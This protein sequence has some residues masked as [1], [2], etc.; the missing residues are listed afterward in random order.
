MYD[1]IRAE[2]L[3]RK[4]LCT[5]EI[6]GSAE[7][8]ELHGRVSFYKTC[9]GSLVAAEICGLPSQEGV[10]AMHIH[11]GTACTGNDNDPFA[12]AGTHL[13][14]TKAEHPYHTGDLPPI[15]SNNGYA[16]FA[17]YTNRFTPCQVIG[18]TVIIHSGSDDLHTQ[19][20]GNAGAK[21]ACGIIKNLST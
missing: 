2:L 13:D 19:P 18:K 12:D 20:S 1:K 15:F 3:L 11:N 4:S 10:Y 6:H 17:V 8:P 14:L 9:H 21:I 16:W 5:A 7:Y